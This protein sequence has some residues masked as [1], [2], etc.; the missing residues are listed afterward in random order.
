MNKRMLTSLVIVLGI[1]LAIGLVWY[2]TVNNQ[3]QREESSS[4]DQS[5]QQTDAA[6]FKQQ[7]PKVAADNR[8]VFA[9]ADEVVDL[10]ERGDGVVFLGFSECSWCQQLAPIVDEAAKAEGLDKIYYLNI[11]EARQN[12]DETYRALVKKLENYLPKD[13]DGNP[14]IFVPDVTVLRQGEIVGR[15][16]QEPTA[17]GEKATSDTYWTSERRERAVAQLQEMMRREDR[18]E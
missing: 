17:D 16:E 6:K 9:N 1:G 2:T 12:N 10:F 3:D 13:K 11:R 18:D 4:I 7:Y 15:F 14:R 5:A 8:F